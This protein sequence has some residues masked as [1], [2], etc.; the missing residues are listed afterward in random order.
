MKKS[1]W[2]IARDTVGFLVF[3]R[4]AEVLSAVAI[5]FLTLGHFTGHAAASDRVLELDC[6]AER[7]KAITLGPKEL[8]VVISLKN[9]R[10]W[11]SRESAKGYVTWFIAAAQRYPNIP[12]QDIEANFPS[13]PTW[14]RTT[15]IS[16]PGTTVLFCYPA[17]SFQQLEA[18]RDNLNSLYRQ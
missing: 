4:R 11:R 13:P 2:T 7:E 15:T 16:E 9:C 18:W 8:R 5:V 3:R 12:Q 1:M 14:E 6:T 17:A 10:C